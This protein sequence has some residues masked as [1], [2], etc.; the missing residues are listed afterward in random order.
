D[1][2]RIGPGHRLIIDPE[3][4]SG[5]LPGHVGVANTGQH[6]A[7]I[8]DV[9]DVLAWQV[10]VQISVALHRLVDVAIDQGH[11]R[12]LLGTSARVSQDRRYGLASPSSCSVC[13]S[14]STGSQ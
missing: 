4:A 8:F 10:R 9:L 13:T 7:E 14:Y 1:Q 11:R 3:V 6:R 12:R 5:S 2:A